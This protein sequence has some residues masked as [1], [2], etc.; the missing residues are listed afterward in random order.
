MRWYLIDRFIEFASGDRAVAVKCVSMAEPHLHD[1][2]KGYPTQPLS[3][4]IEGM[5]QTGGLLV[6]EY[7]QF[8]KKV[9]LAKIAK[10]S[11]AFLPRPGDTMKFSAKIVNRG[12]EGASIEGIVEVEERLLG[13][14]DLFFAFLPDRIDNRKTFS[15]VDYLGMMRQLRILDVG[16]DCQGQPIKPPAR[17]LAEEQAQFAGWAAEDLPRVP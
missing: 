17:M 14:I 10:A 1:Q 12:E 15:Q 13:S 5:A 9:M 7:S 2:T 8:E 3:L 16:V 6:L 4:V 11:F